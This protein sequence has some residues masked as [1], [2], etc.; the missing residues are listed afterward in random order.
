MLAGL[1][2]LLGG[3][4]DFSSA[5]FSAIGQVLGKVAWIAIL[6][7]VA[8][9]L[10]NWAASSFGDIFGEYQGDASYSFAYSFPWDVDASSSGEGGASSS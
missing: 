4:K 9:F 6:F 5:I 7:V 8:L 1:L 2:A 3:I 10:F